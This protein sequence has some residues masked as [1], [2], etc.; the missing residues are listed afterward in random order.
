MIRKTEKYYRK[1]INKIGKN[2]YGSQSIK[3]T[4]YWFLWIIPVFVKNEIISG[5]YEQR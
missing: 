2:Y 4:T 1:E 3:R 5:D